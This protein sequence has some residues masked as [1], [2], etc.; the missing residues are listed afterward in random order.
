MKRMDVFVGGAA[1][2][3]P[4]ATCGAARGMGCSFVGL[5]ALKPAVDSSNGWKGFRHFWAIYPTMWLRSATGFQ[6]DKGTGTTNRP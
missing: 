1:A 2:E 6:A 3:R 4:G 5:A